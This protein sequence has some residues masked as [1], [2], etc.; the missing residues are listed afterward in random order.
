MTQEELTAEQLK[1]TRVKKIAAGVLA[2]IL[3]SL[4]VHKFYLGYYTAGI[5]M[6]GVTAL[7]LGSLA[8]VVEIVGLIEG[9]IY[10]T[11]SDEEFFHKYIENK[12]FMF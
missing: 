6:L 2:I 8:P 5:I 1:K 7:S 4:G 11:R 3:G 10:L 12:R 9:I